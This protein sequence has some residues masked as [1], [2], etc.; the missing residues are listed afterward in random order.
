MILCVQLAHTAISIMGPSDY[1]NTLC[2]ELIHV[3][4]DFLILR[5]Y[6]AYSDHT[7]RSV[8]GPSNYNHALCTKTARGPTRA[9]H[10]KNPVKLQ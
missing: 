4:L 1:N 9:Y 8:T 7:D 10:T 6:F 2:A 3:S 5:I